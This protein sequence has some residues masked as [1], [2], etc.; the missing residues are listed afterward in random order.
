MVCPLFLEGEM[1]SLW[2]ILKPEDR[3]KLVDFQWEVHGF[4]LEGIGETP[5]IPYAPRYPTLD[6]ID[7]SMR[8]VIGEI[9]PVRTRGI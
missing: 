4:K 3:Q 9:S 8:E 7:K 1:P 2:D 6:E 5:P